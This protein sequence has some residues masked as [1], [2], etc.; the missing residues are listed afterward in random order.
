MKFSS[1][2]FYW[3]EAGQ[4]IG[5]N[6]LLSLASV[7]S[8][9]VSLLIFGLFVAVSLNVSQ[10]TQVIEGQVG[11]QA[12]LRTTVASNQIPALRSEIEAWPEVSSVT[13]VSKAQALRNLEQDF[14]AQG[15]AFKP[16]SSDNPLLDSFFVKAKNP[17]DVSAVARRLRSLAAVKNVTY[18][19]PVVTRLF[20]LINDARLAALG[21]GILLALGT[22]LVIQNAIRV[23][24]FARRREIQIMRYVGATEGFIRWPFLLE[25][26]LLGVGG[27]VVSAGVLFLLYHIFASTVHASLP[28]I[29]AVNETVADQI[30]LPGVVAL[31]LVLGFFGSQ[32]SIRR[33][34]V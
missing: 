30:L 8:A 29:P 4:N 20:A 28:F 31:G 21:V 32:F 16:L 25:G 34:R 11:V 24:I 13:F 23:G 12:F 33:V 1:W 27:G 15:S 6:I 22:L 18:Q 10:I 7:S 9:T 2:R 19:A 17:Q 26:M 3:S 5:R 14:G